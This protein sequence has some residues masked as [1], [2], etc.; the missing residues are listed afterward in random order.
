M[1]AG[2]ARAPLYRRLLGDAFEDLAAPIR[3]LHDLAGTMTARG[4]ADIDRGRGILARLVAGVVGFPAAGRDVPVEVT[5]ASEGAAEV[6]TRSFAGKRFS[7]ILGEGRGRAAHLLRESFGPVTFALAIVVKDG[8][9]ELILR[10]WSFLGLTLPLWLAPR[11]LAFE[12]GEDDRFHFHVEIALPLVGL[13][14]RY[15]GWLLPD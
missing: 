13:I 6:W 7:S 15:R 1:N 2:S 12:S 10:R 14:V 8:R 9:L 3:R 11:S 5:I 4:V